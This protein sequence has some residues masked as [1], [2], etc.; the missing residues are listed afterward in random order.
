MGW[1]RM[2]PAMPMWFS[3]RSVTKYLQIAGRLEWSELSHYLWASKTWE[4]PRW[5]VFVLLK[6]LGKIIHLMGELTL[7]LV[8]SS[9][10]DQRPVARLSCFHARMRPLLPLSSCLDCRE[11][12]LHRPCKQ[13]EVFEKLVNCECPTYHLLIQSQQFQ[14]HS[15]KWSLTFEMRDRSGSILNPQCLLLKKSRYLRLQSPVCQLLNYHKGYCWLVERG[16]SR[17]GITKRD[18]RIV[19]FTF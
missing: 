16:T 4:N 12:Q 10:Q 7:N 14:S 3:Q 1:T 6:H 5:K 18:E 15:Q 11:L 9:A 2:E 13:R 17:L 19:A 8:K